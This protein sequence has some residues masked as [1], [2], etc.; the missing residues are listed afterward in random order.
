MKKIIHIVIDQTIMILCNFLFL[1]IIIPVLCLSVFLHS[2]FIIPCFHLDESEKI[3]ER[4]Q[5]ACQYIERYYYDYG[6][7]PLLLED[8]CDAYN[9]RYES[10]FSNAKYVP[11]EYKVLNEKQISLSAVFFDYPETCRK[12]TA[13]ITLNKGNKNE[14]K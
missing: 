7:I 11:F 14:N 6:N 8:V 10:V 5:R 9:I 4:L 1:V 2:I 12:I 3:E 13:F